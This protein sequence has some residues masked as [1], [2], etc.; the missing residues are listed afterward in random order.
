MS[1]SSLIGLFGASNKLIQSQ[2]TPEAVAKE[3]AKE[4]MKRIRMAAAGTQSLDEAVQA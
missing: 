3:A 2:I 1:S 4:A